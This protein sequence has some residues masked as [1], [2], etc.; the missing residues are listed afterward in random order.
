MALSWAVAFTYLGLASHPP[1]PAVDIARL[2]LLGHAA[3][4]GLLVMLLAEWLLVRRQMETPIALTTAALG[5]LGLG[6]AIEVL[7]AGSATRSSGPLDLLADALGIGAGLLLYHLLASRIARPA[8]LTNA[9]VG[10]GAL[11]VVVTVWAASAASL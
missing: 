6:V 1:V 9:L 5:S 7:Q 8:R 11:A 10:L 4:S 3:A 2:D